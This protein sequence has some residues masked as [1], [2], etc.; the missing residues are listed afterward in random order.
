MMKMMIM[1]MMM[2]MMMM[3]VKQSS[4]MEG[5]GQRARIWIDVDCGAM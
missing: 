4:G 2:M 3:T 5:N 1:M